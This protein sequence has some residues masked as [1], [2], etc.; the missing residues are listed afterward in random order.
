[1]MCALQPGCRLGEA[2]IGEERVGEGIEWE[3]LGHRKEWERLGNIEW[4]PVYIHAN[5]I[6]MMVCTKSM[7]G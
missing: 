2:S 6:E 1:M 5:I 7:T 3:R 4:G